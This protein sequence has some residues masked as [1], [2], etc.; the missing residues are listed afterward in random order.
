[1]QLIKTVEI[2]GNWHH[3][4]T[5]QL[6]ALH[7]HYQKNTY[8]RKSVFTYE[9]FE[10]PESAKEIMTVNNLPVK[11][12]AALRNTLSKCVDNTGSGNMN[13]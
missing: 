9:N 7:L 3:A 11:D 5:S 12:Y 13:L 1:V 4:L 8:F 10:L 6:P 2:R